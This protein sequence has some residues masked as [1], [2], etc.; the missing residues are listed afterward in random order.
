MV[1]EYMIQD[2]K[3]SIQDARVGQVTYRI[4]KQ[5]WLQDKGN[6][7]QDAGYTS[8]KQ[9]IGYMSKKKNSV[10]HGENT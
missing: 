7:I 6:R 1:I 2:T 8:R 4:Q 10:L 3:Y 5:G 9:D